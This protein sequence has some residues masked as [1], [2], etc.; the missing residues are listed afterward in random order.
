MAD[1]HFND[2]DIFGLI[3]DITEC[4]LED[5]ENR[6]NQILDV[7]NCTLSVVLPKE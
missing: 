1:N 5:V 4:T 3:A 2:V 7:N 6:L